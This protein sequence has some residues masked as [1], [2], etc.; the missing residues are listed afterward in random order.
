M[1]AYCCGRVSNAKGTKT[2]FFFLWLRTMGWY[3]PWNII[4]KN[5][6]ISIGKS[7]K[8]T[9]TLTVS[10]TLQTKLITNQIPST[11]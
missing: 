3:S 11:K 5:S 6:E 8:S 2:I 1:G 7:Y 4:F 10:F 9:S